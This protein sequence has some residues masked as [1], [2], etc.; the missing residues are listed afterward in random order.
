MRMSPSSEAKRCLKCRQADGR[1]DGPTRSLSAW[2]NG[3]AALL[4][5]CNASARSL[6]LSL[7]AW[8]W[9]C[10]SLTRSPFPQ[11]RRRRAHFS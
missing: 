1:G 11:R 2:N 10:A 3:W 6:A 9:L 7:S 4:P 8:L 5:A